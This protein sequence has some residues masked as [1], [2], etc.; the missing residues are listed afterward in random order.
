MSSHE[1]LVAFSAF[2]PIF[3]FL[4][5]HNGMGGIAFMSKGCL[6]CK[7]RKVKVCDV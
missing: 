2:G 4:S 3:F 1:V 5:R 6:A 7:K